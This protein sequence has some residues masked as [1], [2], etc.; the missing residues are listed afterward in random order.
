MFT[1]CRY[2]LPPAGAAIW[3]KLTFGLLIIIALEVVSF[4]AYVP[5]QAVLMFGLHPGSP[6]CVDVQHR[7]PFSL[8]RLNFIEMAPYQFYFES[9]KQRRV[10]SAQVRRVVGG[11]GR[12]VVFVNIPWSKYS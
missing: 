11:A 7:L 6:F 9:W 2:T 12:D 1:C 3:S 5:F 8:D 10:A 4:R